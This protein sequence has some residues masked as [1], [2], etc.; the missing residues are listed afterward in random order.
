MSGIENL[1][2]E[3]DDLAAELDRQDQR[4]QELQQFLE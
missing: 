1:S 4:I 3:N 2:G